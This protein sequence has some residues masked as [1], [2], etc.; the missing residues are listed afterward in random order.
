MR[1]K[2]SPH[3]NNSILL[4]KNKK[5]IALLY[6]VLNR[7]ETNMRSSRNRRKT[8]S[9]GKATVLHGITQLPNLDIFFRHIKIM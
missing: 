6:P 1:W 7:E 4:P 5:F 3:W 9:S 8:T 2:N